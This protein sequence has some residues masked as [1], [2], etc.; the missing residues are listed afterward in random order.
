MTCS[1]YKHLSPYLDGELNAPDKEKLAE[2]LESCVDCTREFDLMLQ[3]RDSL[4]HGAAL[5]KAPP[6]LKEKILSGKSQ[7]QRTFRIPRV[8]FPHAA[9]LA[10]AVLS[11]SILI[12]FSWPTDRV[13]FEN[14]V[15]IF[16]KQHAA[17]GPGGKSLN[18]GSSSSREAALWLKKRTGLEITVPNAAFAGYKL[19]GVDTFEQMGRKFAYL[20]YQED[21]KTVGYIIFKDEDFSIDLPETEYL[22]K[23]KIYVGKRN[24]TN[25][26]VWKKKGLV[27][28]I[29]TTESRAE[30]MEYARL[31][32]QRF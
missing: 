3:I 28:L 24:G 26:A 27:Y 19:V 18:L 7:A 12:F 6:L 23:I 11:V 17:Y 14:T 13:S 4:R 22:G 2:H 32:I 16:V 30:L 9:G 5:T 15:D 21:D 1:F 31:C 25:L 10:A 29:L 8:K 20:L